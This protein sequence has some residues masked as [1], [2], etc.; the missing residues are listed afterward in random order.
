MGALL[1]GCTKEEAEPVM[2]RVE[3]NLD[4]PAIPFTIHS[5][6]V[7]GQF[8]LD[9]QLDQDALPQLLAAQAY[10]PA[11]ITDLRF[12]TAK[13]HL[14]APAD[15]NYDPLGSISLN[16]ASG[17]GVPVA[18]AGL[19]PVPTGSHTV[20]LNL[21]P[22]NV[23]DLFRNGSVHILAN[24]QLDGELPSVSQHDLVLSARVTVAP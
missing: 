17:D 13:L 11:Q 6:D 14:S 12:T 8:T 5:A 1:Q 16:L 15:G 24:A 20:L 21:E 10:S 22:V 18:V 2:P 3:L 7:N 23:A 9:L 19:N 4:F